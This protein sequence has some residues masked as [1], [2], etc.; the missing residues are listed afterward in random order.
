[1]RHTVIRTSRA[2]AAALCL[3]ALAISTPASAKPG[4]AG[5][6]A[7]IT[8]TFVTGATDNFAHMYCPAGFSVVNGAAFAVTNVTLENG[9]IVT[10]AG[11]RLDLS[12]PLYN[13]WVWNFEWPSG[14]A[15]AGSQVVMNIYCKKGAP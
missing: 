7:P 5:W 12:P 11:P 14:G 15:A 4:A 6:Q 2:F 10:G 13:E 8:I 1:M 9:F 3:G